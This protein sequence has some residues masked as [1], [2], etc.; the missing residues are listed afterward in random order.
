MTQAIVHARGLSRTFGKLKAVDDDT[1]WLQRPM[2]YLQFSRLIQGMLIARGRSIVLASPFTYNSLRR[3]LH[4][5]SPV[6]AE[7]TCMYV[8]VKCSDSC[9]LWVYN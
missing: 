5:A 9:F 3:I 4:T 6:C 1:V 8:C 7:V 2:T